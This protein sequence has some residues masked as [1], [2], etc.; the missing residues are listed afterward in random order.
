MR[1]P[2]PTRPPPPSGHRRPGRPRGRPVTGAVGRRLTVPTP[3]VGAFVRARR[4]RRPHD[5]R[6]AQRRASTLSVG[7]TGPDVLGAPRPAC[8]SSTCTSGPSTTFGSELVDSRRRVPEG[9]RPRPHRRRRRRRPGARSRQD[10][11]PAPR[12]RGTGTHIEVEQEPPDPDGRPRRRDP[13]VPARLVRRRRDHPGRQLPH[14]LEGARRR[15][16]GSA[17][18]SSTGR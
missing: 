11:V 5:H 15:P 6:A 18:R 8:C 17:R 4:G 7:S 13:V 2:R 3:G 9:A 12:Y 10:A 1:R 14:P 16:P